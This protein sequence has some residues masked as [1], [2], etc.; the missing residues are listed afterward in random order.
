[1]WDA[2]TSVADP[3]AQ[4]KPTDAA[5]GRALVMPGARRQ[6]DTRPSAAPVLDA[7]RDR[8]TASMTSGHPAAVL[9]AALGKDRFTSQT[10]ADHEGATRRPTIRHGPWEA[11]RRHLEADNRH[12]MGGFMTVNHTDLRGRTAANVTEVVAY[13]VDF[14][15]AEPPDEYPLP[16]TAVVESSEGR[17]H[18]YWRVLN[19]PVVTFSHVQKYL[20]LLMDGDDTVHDLPRVMRLPGLVHAKREPFISR[21]V[22]VD[23]ASVVEHTVFVDAFAVPP[24]ETAVRQASGPAPG[25]YA[26]LQKYVWAAVQGEHDRVAALTGD[27]ARNTTLHAAAVKLG[28]LVGAGMLAEEDAR[29]ALLAASAPFEHHAVPLTRREALRTIDS[30]LAYGKRHPRQLEGSP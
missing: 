21:L 26:R 15:D 29:D 25:G 1:V 22:L 17:Y 16:P 24:V 20:A 9:L 2:G 28:S 19:A 30:G 5:M 10:F 13:F 14:D 12:G 11:Q 27:G 23:P 8:P 6:A 3:L 18:V 4:R 7:A